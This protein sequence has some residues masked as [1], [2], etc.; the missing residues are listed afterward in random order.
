M[1]Y[2]VFTTKNKKRT[3]K[4]RRIDGDGLNLQTVTQTVTQNRTR[5]AMK[6]Q[7]FLH[8]CLKNGGGVG[9]PRLH[10]STRGKA[11]SV[12]PESNGV[13]SERQRVEGLFGS[14]SPSLM[15]GHSETAVLF[16]RYALARVYFALC[17]RLLLCRAHRGSR[18][19]PGH[20]QRGEERGKTGE[21][22]REMM[23]WQKNR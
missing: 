3:G 19:A 14:L 2:T 11:Y 8:N 6:A 20:A 23:S 13:L 15:A 7:C 16:S 4:H 9:S 12:S 22:R 5:N 18:A 17:G 1:R 21:E 10:H